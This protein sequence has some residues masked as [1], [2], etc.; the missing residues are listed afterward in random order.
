MVQNKHLYGLKQTLYGLK[1]THGSKQTR[2]GFK[3]NI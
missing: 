3:T 1:Q 2:I